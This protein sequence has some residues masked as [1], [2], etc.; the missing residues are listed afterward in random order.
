[1]S[2]VVRQTYGGFPGAGP[3]GG[4]T[5]ALG[6]PQ[7]RPRGAAAG[8]AHA[9]LPA[10]PLPLSRADRAIAW[11]THKGVVGPA[12][13]RMTIFHK[14]R[15]PDPYPA[16]WCGSLRGSRVFCSTECDGAGHSQL[17]IDEF[18]HAALPRTQI[19]FQGL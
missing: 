3:R 12:D 18:L 10:G 15:K 1:M 11:L 16:L 19:Y 7:R 2:I 5:G 14:L 9:I 6:R 4:P 17:M 8:D 13:D